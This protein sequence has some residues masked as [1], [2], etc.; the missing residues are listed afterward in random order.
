MKKET[1]ANYLEKY[2]MD[3]LTCKISIA[4]VENAFED[5]GSKLNPREKLVI[6]KKLDPERTGKLDFSDLIREESTGGIKMAK[7]DPKDESALKDL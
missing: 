2:E 7:L 3:P 4:C 5:I 1:L 6:E